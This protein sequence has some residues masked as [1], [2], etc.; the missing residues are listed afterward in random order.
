VSD[1]ELDVRGA[2]TPDEIAA[3]LAALRVREQQLAPR[4]RYEQWRR[5]RIRALRDNH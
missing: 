3:V 1:D 5:E 2:A 4:R